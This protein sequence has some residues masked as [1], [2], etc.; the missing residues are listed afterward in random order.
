MYLT[1]KSQF[2]FVLGV[3]DQQIP[4]SF[5]QVY[6]IIMFLFCLTYQ[7]LDSVLPGILDQQIPDSDDDDPPR[8][9]TSLSD[10]G[11]TAPVSTGLHS[12][13]NV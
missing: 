3:L 2:L 7:I 9:G 11:R 12:N 4:D 1:K 10:Q 6:F 8:T 13:T 5:Y